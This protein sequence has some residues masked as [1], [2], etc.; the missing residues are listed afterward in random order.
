ME[1][2]TIA[3]SE[4]YSHITGL[5]K[6]V[7]K[8]KTSRQHRTWFDKLHSTTQRKRSLNMPED[9]S[10]VFEGFG[11]FT[12]FTELLMVNINIWFRRLNMVYCCLSSVFYLMVQGESHG[13]Q[14]SSRNGGPSPDFS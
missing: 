1:Q 13:V 4:K 9:N 12:T 6:K 7:V 2:E 10:H 8:K 14:G 5:K 11:P 3:I